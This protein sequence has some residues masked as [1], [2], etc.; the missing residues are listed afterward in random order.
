MGYNISV[1]GSRMRV[2]DEAVQ[3]LYANIRQ[4]NNG[5]PWA[6][7]DMLRSSISV[8]LTAKCNSLRVVRKK[9]K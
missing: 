9:G 4:R 1:G 7:S 2:K 5:G 8:H 6:V 3:N